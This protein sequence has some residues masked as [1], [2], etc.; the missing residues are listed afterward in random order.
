M[1][2]DICCA[3]FSLAHHRTILLTSALPLRL[4][5]VRKVILASSPNVDRDNIVPYPGWEQ[6]SSADAIVQLLDN[7]VAKAVANNVKLDAVWKLGQVRSGGVFGL[8]RK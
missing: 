8:F 3:P 1:D 4:I 5:Q 2:S 6:G 7:D